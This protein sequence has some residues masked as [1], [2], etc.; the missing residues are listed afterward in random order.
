MILTKT[1]WIWFIPVFVVL[2][3]ILTVVAIC[4]CKWPRRK[5]PKHVDPRIILK[6][7]QKVEVISNPAAPE[8]PT[9]PRFM[10][11]GDGLSVRKID[12]TIPSSNPTSDACVN[13]SHFTPSPPLRPPSMHK[14]SS[15]LK[16]SKKNKLRLVEDGDE[17]E[18]QNFSTT[19]PD[20]TMI[21]VDLS[22]HKQFAF[23]LDPTE[24]DRDKLIL[25]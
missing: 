2:V 4:I 9:M 23:N 5:V 21:D 11:A 7:V 10:P 8:S 1:P 25:E 22:N 16:K 24:C 13:G 19:I 20:I 17:V 14:P 12:L 15:R 6:D 3:L 18:C